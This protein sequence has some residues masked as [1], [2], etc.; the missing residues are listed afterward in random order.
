MQMEKNSRINL[1]FVGDTFLKGPDTDPFVL[2][3]SQFANK[4][5]LFG[6]LEVA[7]TDKGKSL[8]KRVSLRVK[9]SRGELLKTVNFD[10][11]NLAN[12]HVFDYGEIG[13]RET[14]KTLDRLDIKHIGVCS[15]RGSSRPAIIKRK[16][17]RIGFLG[18]SN[19]Y[20][21]GKS[22]ACVP[23]DDPLAIKK[24]IGRLKPLVDMVVVS[25]HWGYEYVF[26][27][28]PRQQRLARNIIDWGADIIIG[29]HSHVVQ[30]IEKYSRGLIFYSLGNFQFAVEQ[31]KNFSGTDLGLV[32]KIIIK[33]GKIDYALTPVK[34]DSDLKT[35][36]LAGGE[37]K[38]FLSFIK[39]I[40]RRTQDKKI[41][42]FFW[43]SKTSPIYL[44]SQLQ[45]WIIRVKKYGFS[46]LWK[47]I[48]WICSGLRLKMFV[49]LILG[50]ITRFLDK[51]QVEFNQKDN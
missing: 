4:N 10:I 25:L 36:L 49:F 32:V 21:G 34:I 40:S 23:L 8:D 16:G 1:Y 45:S 44:K 50:S 9:P 15:L 27:P 28:S 2:I 35:S 14:L 11:V 19:F 43:F 51:D 20:H 18:Y 42:D 3:K 39:K 13:A 5:I 24:D 47:M 6:N 26:Y 46:H 7:I 12:N 41:S 30:G 31:D 29:H 37:K 33:E 17:V 48:K 38:H 22:L